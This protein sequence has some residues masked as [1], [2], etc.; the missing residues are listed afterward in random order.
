MIV[1][2]GTSETFQVSRSLVVVPNTHPPAE[3]YNE[4]TLEPSTERQAT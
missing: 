2:V 1:T 3:G 4:A